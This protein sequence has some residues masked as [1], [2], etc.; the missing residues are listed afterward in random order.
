MRYHVWVSQLR[1]LDLEIDAGSREEAERQARLQLSAPS[2]EVGW[3]ASA[4][5]LKVSEADSSRSKPAPA[6]VEPRKLFAVP[7]AADILGIGRTTLYGLIKSGEL[8]SVSVGRRRFVA[9]DQLERFVAGGQAIK[10][11]TR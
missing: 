5:V 1:T 8:Q 9:R 7:Q 11:S 2:D 3:L 4:T 6:S 10:R